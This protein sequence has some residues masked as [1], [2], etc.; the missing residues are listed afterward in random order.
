MCLIY[1]GLFYSPAFQ[2]RIVL[3]QTNIMQGA[4]DKTYENFLMH[5]H[6]FVM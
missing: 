2:L 1:R 3:N 4:C 6:R 5:F